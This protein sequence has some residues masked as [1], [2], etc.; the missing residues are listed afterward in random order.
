MDPVPATAKPRPSLRANH[1]FL[2]RA[3]P[4]AAKIHPLADGQG[5]AVR[6]IEHAWTTIVPGAVPARVPQL[7]ADLEGNH[8]L[9]RPS[10][11]GDQYAAVALQRSRI[12]RRFLAIRGT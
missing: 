6:K 8:G 2:C 5:C 4:N 9:P 7:P 12:S 1:V 10:G 11:H 3:S